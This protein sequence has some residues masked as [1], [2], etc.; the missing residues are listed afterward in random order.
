MDI[1]FVS[2]HG[3]VDTT[4]F[5]LIN[6][7]EILGDDGVQAIEHEDGWP[8]LGIRFRKGTNET[9]YLERLYKAVEQHPDQFDVFTHETMPRRWH[10]S[11]NK[12]I[13]PIYVVPKTNHVLT[14][15]E[16]GRKH[17]TKG[18]RLFFSDNLPIK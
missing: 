8:A 7:D 9:L 16:Q 10:F 2:D 11:N 1:V 4:P 12:R 5:T 17:M 14:T 3:M 15:K 18:V 13:A 6:V